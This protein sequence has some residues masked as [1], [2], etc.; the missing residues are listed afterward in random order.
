MNWNGIAIYMVIAGVL[1]GGPGCGGA[2][3][4]LEGTSPTSAAETE[5]PGAPASVGEPTPAS[6]DARP[7][8][9]VQCADDADCVV[10][11]FAGCCNPCPAPPSAFAKAWLERET[12]EC[13]LVE[14]V[15]DPCV[16]AIEGEKKPPEPA[17][18]GPFVAK[19]DQQRCVLED[20]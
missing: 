1:L 15:D 2:K 8:P 5:A 7:E 11:N 13:G 9:S 14:C 3:Q 10:S 16:E 6:V 17:P 12:M 4:Q 19:C 18:S 20:A